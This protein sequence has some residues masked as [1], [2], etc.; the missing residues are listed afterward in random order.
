MKKLLIWIIGGFMAAI[1]VFFGYVF[2]WYK[3]EDY[4]QRRAFVSSE[5]KDEE[6]ARKPPYPRLRMVDDLLSREK[7]IGKAHA[8]V[9]SLL[10][11]PP[12][13]E[14]FS[15]YDLVYWLGPERSFISIDS[16]WLI[17]KLD[18]SGKVIEC[19]LTTD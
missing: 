18:L 19:A 5:W 1:L 12:K 9:I 6:A 16:E 11:E 8:E 13:T 15:E 3:A 17:M 14:Y 10:G 7:F 4:L 2:Y